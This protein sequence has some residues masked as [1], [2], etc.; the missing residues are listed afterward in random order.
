MFWGY[1]SYEKKGPFHIWKPETAAEKRAAQGEIDKINEALE[2]LAKEN[3]ELEI[4]MKRMGLRTKEG[5]KPVWKW[6]EKHGKVARKGKGGIDWYRYQK[7]VLLPKLLPFAKDCIKDRPDTVVQENRAP[8]HASKH[9]DLVF[10]DAEVLRLLWPGNSPDLNMIEQCWPWMKRQTTRKGAPRNSIT[11][12]KAWTRCWTK[13]L[14]QKI[15]SA[16]DRTNS[17]TYRRS[18]RFE[19]RKR[20]SRGSRQWC[21]SAI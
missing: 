19:W 13:T 4:G 2:P 11:A 21:D 20:V 3:W 12:I 15:N 1:F 16:M 18:Y 6:D 9:Q 10:M 7:T 8:S 17:M 14:K 5:R